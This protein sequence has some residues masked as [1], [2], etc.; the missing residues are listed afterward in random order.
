MQVHGSSPLGA[1]T[2]PEKKDKSPSKF[3]QLFAG[4]KLGN[5]L[6]GERATTQNIDQYKK[7]IYEF[8]E[9]LAS[10]KQPPRY[11]EGPKRLDAYDIEMPVPIARNKLSK[12]DPNTLAV[13]IRNA[14]KLEKQQEAC[15]LRL[16]SKGS[17]LFDSKSSIERRIRELEEMTKV[18]K[19]P[20]SY[21]WTFLD[22][23]RATP[24]EIKQSISNLISK[25]IKKES[26]SQVQEELT[27]TQE[28]KDHRAYTEN[29]R[30]GTFVEVFKDFTTIVANA[31][32]NEDPSVQSAVQDAE[33]VLYTINI[34]K[35]NPKTLPEKDLIRKY[36][37]LIA[38]KAKFQARLQEYVD[39]QKIRLEEIAAQK[40]ELTHSMPNQAKRVMDRL[41]VD[42]MLKL[43]LQD[44]E[45]LSEED[46]NML[47]D[48][49][50][51]LTEEN[52]IKS[53]LE[54][55]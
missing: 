7:A 14:E 23:L 25:I 48:M 52:D 18:L 40:L 26:K 17:T 3:S 46:R 20:S 22:R 29:L 35:S 6:S 38:G 50:N 39:K 21:T 4:A 55:L 51:L 12:I 9:A 42:G 31:R 1:P 32:I 33:D 47:I 53:S 24:A 28:E 49:T 27:P 45:G 10:L 54:K 8:K 19:N 37:Q 11:E 41:G 2:P 5:F 44:V 16:E 43:E 30:R 34:T 36:E 13:L 15:L